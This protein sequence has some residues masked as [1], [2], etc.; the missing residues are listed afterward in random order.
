M[1][2]DDSSASP[3]SAETPRLAGEP[4]PATMPRGDERTQLIETLQD[5]ISARRQEAGGAREGPEEIDLSVIAAIDEAQPSAAEPRASGETGDEGEEEPGDD[6][7]TDEAETRR[8]RRRR[9][10]RGAGQTES[11]LAG[12]APPSGTAP[13]GEA[14]PPPAPPPCPT[15]G[16]EPRPPR[17]RLSAPQRPLGSVLDRLCAFTRGILELCDPQTPTWAQP[18]LAELLAEAGVVP[19]PCQG[20]PHP[21][22]HHVVGAVSGAAVPAG[23]IAEIVS[24]GFCLRGDRGDL[25]PL[26]K[27]EVRIAEGER[28]PEPPPERAAETASDP[29]TSAVSPAEEA[30][31]PQA[32]AS[33]TPPRPPA[34]RDPHRQH[35]P[36]SPQ[37]APPLPLAAQTPEEL[38]ERPKAE[39][40]RALGL[41]D[42]ILADIAALGW[43][44]PTPIQRAAIPLAL[45]RRDILGQAQ[46]GTG[47]TGA[48]ALPLLQRL[49]AIERPR[50]SPP[51]G[52]VLTP[53][54][55]LARQ[56][57]EQLLRMA[58]S[59]GAR[60]A[61][62]Y[63]GVSME[64]QI[65]AL[66]RRPHLVV[67]TPG[68]IID[69]LRRKTLD[70]SALDVLVLDEA[71][72]MLDIG[73]WPDVQYIVGHTPHGRQVLLFSAT[74]PPPI[75]EL[76]SQHLRQPEHICIAPQQVTVEQVDQAYIAVAAERK[77]ELLDHFI[78]RFDPPQ[79]VVFC[80]TK[81]Q[82]DRVAEVL[83]RRGK[84]VAAIH[85]DLPQSRREKTL[86]AFRRGE[87]QCLVAT[88]VAARG[89]DI[90]TVSHV[91]NYDVPETPEEY[92]HRIGR[93]ARNGAPGI[94]RTFVT[95]DDGQFLIEIEKHIGLLLPEER[96]PGFSDQAASEQRGILAETA[97]GSVQLLKPLTGPIRLG[98][99]R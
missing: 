60:C 23:H 51:V 25:F 62:I 59:S 84:S 65:R 95:P 14:A 30:K 46:T 7:A 33:P 99:R 86:D 78:E 8:R 52:L 88:N 64:E 55:E 80:K 48:Y 20:L 85:G 36:E 1:A 15:A 77:T 47:K 31:P 16:Q 6:A 72:Q 71:D 97:P 61:V 69:H 93:T 45:A 76:A 34:G 82:T 73:F 66:A 83:Q 18:R 94:A 22:F 41:N 68:R 13:A 67:G 79:L 12:T 24:P 19:T 50:G 91:V 5:A 4:P 54:R 9:R 75:R 35:P 3:G 43:Q 11:A 53:T 38:A 70:L 96:I 2:H 40:F 49:Y 92:V 29:A 56:V 26:R 28:R 37:L 98:R 21:D 42:Q 74:F 27:A 17:P 39:G 90:P 58:G 63:G 87:L 89:L 81:H 32:V 57:Y 44:E 10:R